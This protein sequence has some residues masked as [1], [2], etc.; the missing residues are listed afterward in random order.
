M[1]LSPFLFFFNEQIICS[2]SNPLPG[3]V[4]NSFHAMVFAVAT[5]AA[6]LVGAFTAPSQFGQLGHFAEVLSLRNACA[7][8]NGEDCDTLFEL[9]GCEYFTAEECILMY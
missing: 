6:I 7:D 4:M 8:G 1:C 2:K 3:E 5:I 9:T